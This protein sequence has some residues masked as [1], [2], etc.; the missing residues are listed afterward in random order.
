MGGFS[1]L[2]ADTAVRFDR[3]HGGIRLPEI[4]ETD[5]C[6]IGPR[7]AMPQATTRPFAVIATDEGDNL[8][9]S[10]AQDRPPPAFPPPFAPNRPDRIDFQTVIWSRGRERRSQGR[11]R[12]EFFLIPAAKAFRETPKIRLMP[13][14]LGRS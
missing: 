10:P 1:G 9:R 13:R 2:F 3:E 11:Q 8:S 5:T 14:I 7:N 4:A 6:P 12:Q